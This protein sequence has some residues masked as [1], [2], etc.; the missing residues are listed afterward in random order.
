MSAVL[1]IAPAEVAAHLPV[2]AGST[3]VP[4]TSTLDIVVSLKA[5]PLPAVVCTDTISD[6]EA[7]SVAAAV[8]DR[9]APCIEVRL[10]PWDGESHSPIGAVCRGVISGFGP[11][12]IARAAEFLRSEARA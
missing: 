10:G 9:K 8:R 11:N 1:V 2:I 4:V 12:A 3:I 6:G 5:S 7:E